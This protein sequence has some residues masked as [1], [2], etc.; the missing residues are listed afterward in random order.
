MCA[1]TAFKEQKVATVT[2]VGTG[3][4]LQKQ[5]FFMVIH[6]SFLVHSEFSALPWEAH[7]GLCDAQ[8][9]SKIGSQ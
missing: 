4:F 5:F 2:Q 9:D 1:F 6:Q 8:T 7:V 3:H